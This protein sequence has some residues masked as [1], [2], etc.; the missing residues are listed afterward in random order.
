MDKLLLLH[1]ITII[2]Q[3]FFLI[4]ARVYYFSDTG[5]ILLVIPLTLPV[6]WYRTEDTG[7]ST[8]KQVAMITYRTKHK[9]KLKKSFHANPSSAK[10]V[11]RSIF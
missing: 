8:V 6:L 3:D 1:Q 4:K 10:Y 5:V 11:R 2:D 9:L 7:I